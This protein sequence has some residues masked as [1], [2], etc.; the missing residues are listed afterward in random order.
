MI[1]V[2]PVTGGLVLPVTYPFVFF[3]KF[4]KAI[5]VPLA[6][7]S[8]RDGEF[9]CFVAISTKSGQFFMIFSFFFL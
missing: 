4:R 9:F 8:L 6:D 1:F 7:L 3:V 2:V 5:S